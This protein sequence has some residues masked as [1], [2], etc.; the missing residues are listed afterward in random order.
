M[1]LYGLREVVK[2]KAGVVAEMNCTQNSFRQTVN[3]QFPPRVFATNFLIVGIAFR[4]LHRSAVNWPTARKDQL[5]T[6]VIGGLPTL[7]SLATHK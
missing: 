5:K 7:P 2:Q 6:K 1:C 4:R 3:W